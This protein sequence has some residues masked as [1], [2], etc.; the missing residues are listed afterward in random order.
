[1]YQ[2]LV[3]L[4]PI[5]RSITGNGLR[6]SLSI[7]GKQIPLEIHE[8]P[9]GTPVL[10]W[11]IP[12]EWNIKDAYIRDPDGRKVVDLQ[13]SNLHIVNYSHPIHARLPLA[14]LKDHLYTLPDQPDYGQIVRRFM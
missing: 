3:E 10:D 13:D 14:Q 12:R 9:T 8:V 7:I 1:M 2:L 5:C 6:E 4:Y 11:V